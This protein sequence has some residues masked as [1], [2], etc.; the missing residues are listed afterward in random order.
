MDNLAANIDSAADPNY[1]NGCRFHG[2]PIRG[3]EKSSVYRE[4]LAQ[5]KDGV[6]KLYTQLGAEYGLLPVM[7]GG[8]IYWGPLRGSCEGI[9]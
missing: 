9:C 8:Q 5:F 7:V 1:G 2:C 6:G 4:G 3:S